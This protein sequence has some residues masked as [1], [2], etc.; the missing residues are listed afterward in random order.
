MVNTVQG[1]DDKVL[2][3]VGG[4]NS[5]HCGG[6]TLDDKGEDGDLDEAPGSDR[7]RVLSPDSAAFVYECEGCDHFGEALIVF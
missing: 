2:E 3:L 4:D 1:L 7:V 6:E 5:L